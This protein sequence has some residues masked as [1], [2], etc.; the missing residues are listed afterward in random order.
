MQRPNS[1]SY[2]S[3]QPQPA[4]K[5]CTYVALGRVKRYWL[6]MCWCAEESCHFQFLLLQYIPS[7]VLGPQMSQGWISF[8]LDF[9]TTAWCVCQS[10]TCVDSDLGVTSWHYKNVMNI[11]MHMLYKHT[12]RMKGTLRSFMAWR[13][14]NSP[15]SSHH[16]LAS[17][18]NFFTSSGSTVVL[19]TDR[20]LHRV[21]W[22]GTHQHCVCLNIT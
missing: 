22:T 21:Q 14:P 6:K 3:K 8:R 11:E 10:I 5:T 15:C 7:C 17:D 16:L 19:E 2:Q 18:W 13:A 1:R 9:D 20:V 4:P 12:H